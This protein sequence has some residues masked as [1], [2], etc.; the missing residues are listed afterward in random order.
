MRKSN[1]TSDF[2][3]VRRPQSADTLKRSPSQSRV[4]ADGDSPSKPH[5]PWQKSKVD[6]MMSTY[7]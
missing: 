7:S 1:S 4:G 2:S 6:R 3:P 5:S